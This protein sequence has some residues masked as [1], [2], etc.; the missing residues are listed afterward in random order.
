MGRSLLNCLYKEVKKVKNIHGIRGT[1][2][3]KDLDQAGFYFSKKLKIY[4]PNK[5]ITNNAG[6][7]Y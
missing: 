2:P 3:A 1:N 7:T 4:L 6:T 5:Y